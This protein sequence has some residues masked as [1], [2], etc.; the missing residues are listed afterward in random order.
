[1]SRFYLPTVG[2]VGDNVVEARSHRGLMV[3]PRTNSDAKAAASPAVASCKYLW[4]YVAMVTWP[5][6]ELDKCPLVI[7]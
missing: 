7:G 1:M 3:D 6:T 4:G 2:V 5:K